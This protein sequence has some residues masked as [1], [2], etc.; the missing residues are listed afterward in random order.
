MSVSILMELGYSSQKPRRSESPSIFCPYPLLSHSCCLQAVSPPDSA[1]DLTS[2]TLS[3]TWNENFEAMIPSRVSA[4]FNFEV[5]DWNTV[6]SSTDLGGGQ[7]DLASLE[8]FEAQELTI[9]IVHPEK[10]EKGSLDIRLLFQPES[11]CFSLTW[12]SYSVVTKLIPVI[13]RSRHKTSTFSTAGRVITTVGA[14]PMGVGKGAIKGGAFVA[15][16]AIHGGGAVVGGVGHGIGT[17]GGFAGR[18]I[19][20]IKKKDKSGK[21]V[22]VQ[23]DADPNDPTA[24]AQAQSM[25]MNGDG[26]PQEGTLGVTVISGSGLVSKEGSGVKPYVVVK[27]GGKSHKTGHGKGIEPEW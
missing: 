18:K 21:E 4:K 27:V 17:V 5:Q 7:I 16:H 3:P 13:A 22:L 15:G 26:V 19:G 25:S 8:P 23:A 24:V 1:T 9:P 14:V 20:L 2:R 12:T 10:G 11:M 6:G